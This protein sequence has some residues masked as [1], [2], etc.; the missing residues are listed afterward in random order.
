MDYHVSNLDLIALPFEI[1]TSNYVPF[2]YKV[3]Q[4]LEGS[5]FSIL[6]MWLVC[7]CIAVML[8]SNLLIV[9]CY[10]KK[11]FS[12]FTLSNYNFHLLVVQNIEAHSSDAS[13]LIP[14]H[15]YKLDVHTLNSRHPGEVRIEAVQ[16]TY[17]LCIAVT[18]C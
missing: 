9:P 17:T 8:A 7:L 10:F 6:D 14:Q 16:L 5:N 11:L 18:Q 12:F 3:Q 13:Q 15:N 4:I 2:V 1:Q